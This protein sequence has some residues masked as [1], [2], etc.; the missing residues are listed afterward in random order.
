MPKRKQL[1]G[2][3]GK[4]RPQQQLAEL[5]VR[6]CNMFEK[7]FIEIHKLKHSA[8]AVTAGT[9]ED[10]FSRVQTAV[11]LRVVVASMHLALDERCDKIWTALRAVAGDSMRH[12]ATAF[13]ARRHSQQATVPASAQGSS[14]SEVAQAVA[15][16]EAGPSRDRPASSAGPAASS[17]QPDA[18]RAAP[19]RGHLLWHT[20]HQ[21][22][23]EC[24][25]AGAFCPLLPPL[26]GLPYP[27]DCHD[28]AR[29][30]HIRRAFTVEASR[31]TDSAG[32]PIGEVAFVGLFLQQA[33]KL[34]AGLMPGSDGSWPADAV[35]GAVDVWTLWQGM[36]VRAHSRVCLRLRPSTAAQPVQ[37]LGLQGRSAHL[38]KAVPRA[39][40]GS[41]QTA[42]VV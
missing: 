3:C 14:N 32:K 25:A 8:D 17:D 6:D 4:Q 15:T 2:V 30:D 1:K 26:I 12:S 38:P 10:A 23:T 21:F 16:G 37:M 27:E 20:F 7:R 36:Q 19:P 24:K 29:A 18:R 11:I 35:Q 34:D 39:S 22:L 41:G 42:L 5:L 28:A 40:C 9:E 13:K 33:M 31:D